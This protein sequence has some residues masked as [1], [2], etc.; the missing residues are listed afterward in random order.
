MFLRA[1]AIRKCRFF[2]DNRG[3]SDGKGFEYLSF[4]SVQ[5]IVLLDMFMHFLSDIF[6]AILRKLISGSFFMIWTA[7]CLIAADTLPGLPP[8][9]LCLSV[10]PSASLF[11]TQYT[12]VLL[13]S[14]IRDISVSV[15]PPP[16]NKISIFFRVS[17][18]L[19]ME[20]KL[21]YNRKLIDKELY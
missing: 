13:M 15:C 4:L 19:I 18:W 16:F 10:V 11:F 6:T 8:P 14:N 1:H 9:L 7:D 3:I 2:S 17:S 12:V 21:I 20:K 5:W